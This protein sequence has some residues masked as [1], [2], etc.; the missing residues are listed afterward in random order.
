MTVYVDDIAIEFQGRRWYHM[1]ADTEEELHEFAQKIGL[2][3]EWFQGDHYDL[4]FI[5]RAHAITN[6]AKPITTKKMVE[7]RK[8]KRH[9]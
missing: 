3:K 9:V 5:K 7:I 8:A 2:R 1:M 4:T 6:G